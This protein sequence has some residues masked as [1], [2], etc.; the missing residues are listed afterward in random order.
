MNTKESLL[1]TKLFSQLTSE[2]LDKLCQSVQ[3]VTIESNT[4]FIRKNELADA[5]YII[6][7]GV[8]Q[9][10]TQDAAGHEI[11]LSRLEEGS[12]FG[13]QAL[14]TETPGCRN[15]SI[16]A[17]NEMKLL[18][19]THKDF[20]SIL[21]QDETL[22]KRLQDLGHQ[23]LKS[24]LV[25]EELYKTYSSRTRG[26]IRQ[27]H[28]KFLEKP[29]II[30]SF[31]LKDGREIFAARAVEKN[32]HSIRDTN[33]TP[34]ESAVYNDEFTHREL[35]LDNNCLVGVTSYGDWIN[36]SQIISMIFNQTQLDKEQLDYF[37]KHGELIIIL[38]TATTAVENDDEIICNCMFVSLKQIKEQMDAGTTEID[39]IGDA[40]G[41]GTVCGTCRAR[42]QDILGC[43]GWQAV[44]IKNS[45]P[46]TPNIHAYQLIPALGERIKE[47]KAGQYV[48]MQC[49]IDG[50]WVNR[51]YTLTSTASNNDYY[52]VAI[53]REDKGLFSNWIFKHENTVPLLRISAPDGKF[54]PNFNANTPI[55]CLMAGIGITPAIAFARA[56][57]E[58]N[59]A[60]P[61]TIH[62]SA[63]TTND[64]AYL[65]ELQKL[66]E[67]HKEIKL[68]TRSTK[69][70][71]RLQ[72]NDLT[73]LTENLPNAEYFIC[74]PTG[75]ETSIQSYL[76]TI[77]IPDERV[78]IEKFTHSFDPA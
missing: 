41:A 3:E 35:L 1:K 62:F 8:C 75:Y 40:T 69:I 48:V 66:V 2:E 50:N 57:V 68:I 36:L 58:Q 22:K 38:P 24:N 18:K 63:H 5:L 61:L 46:L 13:E 51:S 42:I 37:K 26:E 12:Y 64:F 53:Q 47:Y 20:Q 19:I 49:F 60:R 71:G 21:T 28:G 29:A 73:G 14:L 44:R 6:E 34:T 54:T 43:G 56:C 32:I 25:M 15:A 59:N 45:F 76:K 55:I 31:L 9:V 4:T 17:L 11:I 74:G 52:E 16:R 10:F 78:F 7:A 23:Q 33:A 72:Q 65:A 67:L 30:T 77:G 39:A 70:E 27:Y